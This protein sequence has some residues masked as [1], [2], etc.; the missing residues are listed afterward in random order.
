MGLPTLEPIRDGRKENQPHETTANSSNEHNGHNVH[1]VQHAV[2][3]RRKAVSKASPHLQMD[4]T[5]TFHWVPRPLAGALYLSAEEAFRRRFRN[6]FV[7]CIVANR[8]SLPLGLFNFVAPLRL[9]S[10]PEHE[11]RDV[12]F[13]GEGWLHRERS[14]S[15][16]ALPARVHCGRVAAEPHNAVRH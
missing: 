13:V 7:G 15:D 6:H 16:R 12:V 9:L 11:L 1:F 2:A 8:Q 14:L 10:I 3:H 4:R 5:G